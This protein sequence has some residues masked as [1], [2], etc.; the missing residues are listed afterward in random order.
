MSDDMSIEAMN[1][2]SRGKRAIPSAVLTA[3]GSE[4]IISARLFDAHPFVTAKVTF[5]NG[6]A[7]TFP[8]KILNFAKDNS[9]Y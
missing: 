6:N 2:P 8:K 1:P 4:G 7:D 5:I 3:S 9:N